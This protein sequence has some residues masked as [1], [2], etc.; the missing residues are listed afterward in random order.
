MIT[1]QPS[2][3]RLLKKSIPIVFYSLLAIFLVLYLRTINFNALISIEI[4]YW[5]LAAAI[6]FGLLYRFWGVYIWLTI[7]RLLGA[8]KVTSSPELIFVYAKSWL[9][10]YMPGSAGWILGKIYFA[11]QYG[12]SKNKLAVSTILEAALQVIVQLAIALTVLALDPRLY[13]IG[14]PLLTLMIVGALLLICCLIPN[15]FNRIFSLAYQLLRRKTFSTTHHVTPKIVLR[16]GSLYA[17]ATVIDGVAFYLIAL[18]IY[19]SIGIE[20]ILFV[21]ATATLATAVSIL[22]IFA[23]SGIGVR[24]GVQLLLLSLIM[25]TEYALAITVLTRLWSIGTDIL[26]YTLASLYKRVSKQN[27]T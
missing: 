5:I 13:V 15:V 17:G 7:L 20:N 24:E 1:I 14:T 11:S 4:N 3:V 27:N 10:R 19:P 12:I 26:F 6:T 16:G 21:A 23:P 25:P 2:I 9:G 22:A 8:K 18:A